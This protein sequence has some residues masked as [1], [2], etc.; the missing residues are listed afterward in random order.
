MRVYLGAPDGGGAAPGVV[1]IM[2]GP[3]LERFMED[4]VEEL[5]RH[6]YAAA[7]PD[8]YHRQPQDGADMMAKIGRLRDAEI[9]ADVDATIGHLRRL[10]GCA[11]G[12]PRGARLLHG[13]AD[14][15]P[16]RRRAAVRVEGG[17]RLLRRQHH[18]AVGRRT[19]AVRP[20]EGASPVR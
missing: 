3:G 13:R 4:R 12:R 5:A 10:P 6:G 15:L 14:H 20:D 7:C 1:V 11:R 17:G 9:I 19:G 18:E 8:L 2:H 16:A